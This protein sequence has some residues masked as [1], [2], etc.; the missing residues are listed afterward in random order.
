MDTNTKQNYHER[1]NLAHAK[2][3]FEDMKN[4]ALLTPLST[5]FP[6]LD[7]PL[8]GGVIPG[9]YI[10]GA[11]SSLGK[12]TF[13]SQIA[14]SMAA[15]GH[16]ILYVSMEMERRQL[17]LKS[18]SRITYT[19]SHSKIVSKSYGELI[20]IKNY[21]DRPAAERKLIEASFA[22]YAQ[23][24][25]NIYVMDDIFSTSVGNIETAVVDHIKCTGKTPIVIIDYLQVLSGPRDG[26]S[27]K[28]AI[29][30]AVSKLKCM[31]TKL[32]VIIIAVSSLN[33]ASY[34][35]PV[36][37]ESFKEI[38]GIEYTAD[39]LIG[40]Q[41]YGLEQNPKSFDLQAFKRQEVRAME[42]VILKNRFGPVDERVDFD[43]LPRFNYFTE[44]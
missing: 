24:A 8:G 31:C 3:L 29:D 10:I 34:R 39:V 12:T 21:A 42:L 35:S 1:S 33:R 43:Y 19:L 26:A 41:P 5:G 6:S 2:R 16:D 44:R 37:L 15:A 11:V 17:V 14:D 23:Y 22:Q 7:A 40:L 28:Q 4:G 20:Q 32:G 25:G 18:I 9:L 36:S 30:Y 27:D 38:G 13:V